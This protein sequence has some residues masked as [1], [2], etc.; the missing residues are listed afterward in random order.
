MTMDVLSGTYVASEIIRLAPFNPHAH[1]APQVL[2][3]EARKIAGGDHLLERSLVA[4]VLALGHHDDTPGV[5]RALLRALSSV[6]NVKP[7]NPVPAVMN[8]SLGARQDSA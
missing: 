5:E 4:V 6:H 1:V 3:D 8:P 2:F 7:L